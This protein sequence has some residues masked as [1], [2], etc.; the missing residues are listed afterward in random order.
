MF[1]PTLDVEELRKRWMELYVNLM[2]LLSDNPEVK[3]LLES[4]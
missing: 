2:A 3:A 1:W 4:P